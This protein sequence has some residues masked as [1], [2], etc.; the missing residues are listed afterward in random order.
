MVCRRNRSVT[1]S[2]EAAHL[3]GALAGTGLSASSDEAPGDAA[4]GSAAAAPSVAPSFPGGAPVDAGAARGSSAE[5]GSSVAAAAATTATMATMAM[6]GGVAI[7][8]DVSWRD[9]LEEHDDWDDW[10]AGALESEVGGAA[11]DRAAAGPAASAATALCS[12]GAG[13]P[14]SGGDNNEPVDPTEF[15]TI[16]I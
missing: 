6:E 7:L 5:A 8:V 3:A 11:A 1:R 10:E 16:E 9:S 15:R 13:L 12:C 2:A 4:P 14:W